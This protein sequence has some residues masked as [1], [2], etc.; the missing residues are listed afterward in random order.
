MTQL[1]LPSI[2]VSSLEKSYGSLKA[3]G[4][5]SFNIEPGEIFSLLGPNGAGKT[6]TIEI[7][8][9]LREKDSG[10][11]NVLGLDPWT[12]GY[13]L[14]RK[15]GVMPQGFR[16]FDY[17]T[18]K[19]AIKYYADLFGVRV[20]TQ[21]ILREVILEDSAD[22]YF[23]RLSGGQ[24]QKVGLALSLVND[25]Q[26]VFLDEPTT[27]LDPQARRAVWVV[28]RNLKKQGRSVMLTTHYLQEAQ[29]LADRV[30]IMNKGRI[31]THGTSEEIIEKHGSGERVTVHGDE[32][33]AQYLKEKTTLTVS[34]DDK[35]IVSILLQQK[36]DAL[37]ALEAIE[38]SGMNWGDLSTQKD[39]LEEV[40]VRLVGEPLADEAEEVQV[41]RK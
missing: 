14:H 33:L 31:I 34:Y 8:E 2:E 39:D 11:V 40:F 17:A 36:H 15:I 22:T 23:S 13:E 41:N 24:K 6:T 16:F 5:I 32:K 26:V 38:Q 19:D 20:D 27:G 3:V 25:P 18:P 37:V 7:L 28:I 9:G 1:R 29:E 4:G 10:S 12:N 30:A 21:T 35:G